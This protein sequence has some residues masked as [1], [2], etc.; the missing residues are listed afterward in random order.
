MCKEEK[1]G[2]REKPEP[3]RGVRG[4]SGW[5]ERGLSESGEGCA[6]RRERLDL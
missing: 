5:Q 6:T 4:E 1:M 3:D 2:R